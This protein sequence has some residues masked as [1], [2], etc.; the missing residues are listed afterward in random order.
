M[1][2]I[3]FE[4]VFN[5]LNSAGALVGNIIA[6]MGNNGVSMFLSAKNLNPTPTTDIQMKVECLGVISTYEYNQSGGLFQYALNPA[7]DTIDAPYIAAMYQIGPYGESDKQ[8]AGTPNAPQ[9]NYSPEIKFW[10]ES[11]TGAYETSQ[12]CI[13]KLNVTAG[14]GTGTVAFVSS[15]IE[16]ED[17][18]PQ[19]SVPT[20]SISGMNVSILQAEGA[21]VRYTL[22]GSEPSEDSTLYSAPFAVEKT[23]IIKAIGIDTTNTYRNSEISSYEAVPTPEST[24]GPFTVK[25]IS[26]LPN[27]KIGATSLSDL[28]FLLEK[29]NNLLQ[30]SFEDLLRYFN[31]LYGGWTQVF[32]G[33]FSTYSD[34]SNPLVPEVFYNR[35]MNL[36]CGLYTNSSYKKICFASSLE[37]FSVTSV[38]SFLSAEIS[39]GVIP[40]HV[41]FSG[42]KLIGVVEE[43]S[44]YSLYLF[45]LGSRSPILVLITN[46]YYYFYFSFRG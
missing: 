2:K 41:F 13:L 10:F 36:Y 1:S 3:T 33:E 19:L 15:E 8:V 37:S 46:F 21:S 31:V 18:R 26:Q 17:T 20:F 32:T 34:F 12:K 43:S 16:A 38:G 28:R 11:K 29:D 42:G 4:D 45:K 30:T 5:E 35:E 9:G 7:D 24:S 27:N 14:T 44:F 22:D 23:T 39:E 6:G 40:K 25:K